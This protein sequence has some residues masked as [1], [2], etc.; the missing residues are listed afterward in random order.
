MMLRPAYVRL[1]MTLPATQCYPTLMTKRIEGLFCAGQIN[2]T[3]G[4]EEAAKSVNW[5]AVMRHQ[6]MIVSP[7][8][9]LHWDVG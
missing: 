6:E 8:A 7:R 5:R 4:Y 2:G 1:S 9:E 3:T